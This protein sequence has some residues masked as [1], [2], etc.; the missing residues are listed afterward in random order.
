MT[1]SQKF[2]QQSQQ[3]FFLEAY[4]YLVDWKI[5][6]K[7]AYFDV[8]MKGKED[9]NVINQELWIN[10]KNRLLKVVKHVPQKG[11]L[12]Y[13]RDEKWVTFAELNELKHFVYAD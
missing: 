13:K 7:K 6:W 2:V 5:M 1:H 10:T 12:S 9:T 4:V 8:F 11:I 3:Y